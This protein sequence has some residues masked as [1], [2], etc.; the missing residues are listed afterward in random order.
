MDR[1]KR[2][3][4]T[5]TNDLNFDQRMI[6][7]CTSL[8]TAG[9]DVLLV[10]RKLP[11][12]IPLAQLTFQ[13]KRFSCFFQR[14]K[15]F[16]L[17][18]NLRL[19]L[20]LLFKRA[21][22]IC[23]IDLDTLLA[24]FLASKISRKKLVYDAHEYY[25]EVPELVHRKREQRIWE[26]LADAIIPRVTYAYTVCESLAEIFKK[27]YGTSFTVIRNLPFR[28]TTKVKE[29]TPRNPAILLYQGALNDG[30]GIAE[31]LRV[32]PTLE[33]V[34]LRLAGE[35]DLSTEL[36][37]LTRSLKI[38]DRVEF[39]GRVRPED[40]KRL[41]PEVTIGLN[42]LENKGLNYYYSLANKAFD[43][44]QAELPAIHMNFPEY[45]KINAEYEVA[46][47]VDDLSEEALCAAIQKLL[48]DVNLY[49]TLKTNCQKAKIEYTWEKEARRLVAFYQNVFAD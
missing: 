27:K 42:L 17:E 34:I 40:L 14:G 46:I 26:Y 5:V 15:F 44:I 47:L 39:L 23:A 11:D 32:L 3:V 22:L 9:Y 1:K 30:R 29:I 4:C 21:D 31:I 10:G 45:Q 18:Y 36:R 6:R 28:S 25:T 24:G 20:F 49:Q 19:F 48:Q 33:N 12:S 41:T 8:T 35:G 7:I 37:A 13:Q 38:E 2:I 43:Y 16:Y